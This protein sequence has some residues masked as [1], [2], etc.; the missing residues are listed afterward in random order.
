MKAQKHACFHV[1]FPSSAYILHN[2]KGWA[3]TQGGLYHASAQDEELQSQAEMME[4]L[5]MRLQE[6]EESL[7][8]SQQENT[9]LKKQVRPWLAGRLSHTRNR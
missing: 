8:A 2:G 5:T 4:G 3:H 6:V 1:N 7:E 9:L